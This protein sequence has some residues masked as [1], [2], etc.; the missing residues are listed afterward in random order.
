MASGKI[1]VV[2]DDR[3]LLELIRMRL[4]A[5]DF[6]VTT[7]LHEDDAKRLAAEQA[8]D[9][10]IIDLQLVNQDGIS[11]MEEL[12]CSN[13]D[14]PAIILTAH[15][16]IE[17]AVE[18]IRRGAYDYL[19][20]PFDPRE[21]ILHIEKAIE[22]RRLTSEVSRLKGL[23]SEKYN[24]SN[25]VARSEKMQKVLEHV[26][27]VARTDSTVYIRGE[28]GTGKE[29]IVKAIHMVSERRDGPFVAVNCAALPE[30][31]LESELL[32]YKRGAFTGAV[33]SRKG[34]LTQAHKGTIFLDEIAE[35]PLS[36]QV[37]FLRVLQ[38]RQFYPLGSEEPV[39]VDVRVIVATN[40]DLEDKVREGRFREDLYYRIN[41]IPIVLPPLRERKEDI[42]PLADH[43][44][45]K[46]SGDMGRKIKGLSM[47]AMHK[48]ML[49]DWPG[50]VRELENAMEYA[51]AMSREDV[52]NEELVLASKSPSERI[53]TLKEAREAFEK[54]YIIGLLKLTGGNVSRAAEKAGKYR[55]DFYNLL[56]K[57]GI[58][59]EEFKRS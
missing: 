29:L 57:Y 44:L 51:V 45:K 53:K 52:I 19:T 46:F 8:F 41:V 4:E 16:S 12:H 2:D 10:S 9:L 20:K 27:Y 35:M 48:L 42:P 37:K 56:K 36:V 43:F 40:R 34:L 18:A 38:E 54:E 50:N 3:N 21:L 39:N 6:E 1:L 23:L 7:S 28:S 31:L 17:S 55:A 14:M 11:L 47:R 24:F 33:R 32:G 26:N 59:P 30:S 58:R 15:G 25:I 13:P 49:Y 5:S 22:K